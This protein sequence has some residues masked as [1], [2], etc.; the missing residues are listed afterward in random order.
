M[1]LIIF[2]ARQHEDLMHE[3]II[4]FLRNSTGEYLEKSMAIT[5]YSFTKL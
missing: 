1:V 5:E 2:P 4:I 3:P